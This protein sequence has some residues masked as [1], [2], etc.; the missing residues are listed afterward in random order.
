MAALTVKV[1]ADKFVRTAE[2]TLMLFASVAVVKHVSSANVLHAVLPANVVAEITLTV[3]VK[4]VAL[5]NYVS[6]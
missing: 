4:V 3:C 1:I 2:K 6:V 5:L